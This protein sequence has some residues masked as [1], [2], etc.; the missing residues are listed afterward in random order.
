MMLH[1]TW[2]LLRSLKLSISLIICHMFNVF[3]I[4]YMTKYDL[5]CAFCQVLIDCFYLLTFKT[6]VSMTVVMQSF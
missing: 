2:L 6:Y 4:Q 3:P 5:Y 1:V